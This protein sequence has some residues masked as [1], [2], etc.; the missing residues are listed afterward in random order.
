[1]VFKTAV[2][3]SMVPRGEVGLIFAE[4]GRA[5]GVFDPQVYAALV[6]VIAYTT[7]LAPFWIKLFYRRYGDHPSLEFEKAL[8]D[9]QSESGYHPG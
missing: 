9:E 8:P 1:M 5:S 4:L 6:I 7:I 2:G 3:I